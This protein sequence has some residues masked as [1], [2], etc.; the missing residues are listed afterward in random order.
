MILKSAAVFFYTSFSFRFHPGHAFTICLMNIV[1]T[2]SGANRQKDEDIQTQ[3]SLSKKIR[4]SCI[5][6]VY[7]NH[8][9]V[10]SLQAQKLLKQL[11]IFTKIIFSKI[12]FKSALL[13]S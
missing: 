6:K 10:F 9:L 13:Q 3:L 2:F 4:R 11:Y 1:R 12:F 5:R 8:V 7:L